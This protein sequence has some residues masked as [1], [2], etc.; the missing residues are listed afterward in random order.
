MILIMPLGLM[1]LPQVA[2]PEVKLEEGL[3][4]LKGG[5]LLLRIKITMGALLRLK[6]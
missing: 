4:V 1:M 5:L 6:P 2:I 3:V